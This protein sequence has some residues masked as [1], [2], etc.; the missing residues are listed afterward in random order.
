MVTATALL[1]LTLA[2]DFVR[3]DFGTTPARRV[4]L[5]KH[6]NPGVRRRAAML[7]AHAPADTAI[8]GLLVA[9][10]DGN[11]G[12]RRTAA[13]S[14]A[15]LADERA[16]PFLVRAVQRE[17]DRSV[18]GVLLIALA[19]CGKSYVARNIA[20]FLNSP[21]R[22]VRASAAEGL[23]YVGDAGQRSVLWDALRF[24]PDDPGFMVRSAVLGAFV[25]Q[26]WRDDT[27]KAVG[28]LK[29][30]GALRHWRS[31]V[32]VIASVGAMRITSWTKW[33]RTE[34]KESKDPRVVAA[35]AGS[36]ALLGGR[37]EVFAALGHEAPTVRRACLVAL[38]ETADKRATTEALRMVREDG[39]ADVRFEAALVLHRAG[40]R[41]ADAYLVDALRSRNALYWITALGA[42]E[43]RHKRSFGRDP[44][45]WTRFLS[46]RK[47]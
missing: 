43:G 38:Q 25:R 27:R 47:R 34:L 40:H 12:V 46:G 35:A 23:G 20:P 37:D 29:E 41:K 24:A 21:Y 8:A 1:L 26:G 4:K 13:G 31:R 2:P 19:R 18:Q 15:W 10:S 11:R 32:A 30:M 5:L 7:L 6:E 33:V 17:S 28:E 44:D 22:T 42:L 9:L 36:L 14:L 16:V 45:A 3:V 39:S